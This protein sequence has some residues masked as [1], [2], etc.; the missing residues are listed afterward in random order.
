M[1]DDHHPRPGRTWVRRSRISGSLSLVALSLLCLPCAALGQQASPDPQ[2]PRAEDQDRSTSPKPGRYYQ[3]KPD[4]L[5]PEAG[6]RRA[7]S[8]TSEASDVVGSEAGRK[9]HPESPTAESRKQNQTRTGTKEGRRR[10][11]QP[12]ADAAEASRP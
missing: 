11:N 6:S 5:P 9:S 7:N 2:P 12:E 10:H 4:P 1:E 3:A 8:G